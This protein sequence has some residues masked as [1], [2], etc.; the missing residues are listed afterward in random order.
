[1]QNE[2]QALHERH[3]MAVGEKTALSVAS[4]MGRVFEL[5]PAQVAEKWSPSKV[6]AHRSGRLRRRYENAFKS[7]SEKSLVPK[8]ANIAMFVKFEKEWSDVI[9]EKTPRAIQ[10]RT[11]RYTATISQYL[12]PIEKWLFGCDK[13]WAPNSPV[14][15]RI[16]AKG[17]NS[18]DR[19]SRLYSMWR[20]SD[21]T[22]VLLDHSRF[23]AN[24]NLHHIKWEKKIYCRLTAGDT[25]E[26]EELMNYQFRNTCYSGSGIKY[27][28]SGKKMSGEYNTSLGDSIINAS[29][30]QKWL[31]GIDA[32]FIVDGDDSVVA[33][34]T[35]D[36]HKLDMCYFKNN[37]WDTKIE[38]TR[39]FNHVEFCQARPVEIR[40][41]VWRMVRNPMRSL[42]RAVCTVQRYYG[43][44]WKRYLTSIGLCE[45][46]CGFG[47]PIL[48]EFARYLL[49]HGEGA[50]PL[51]TIQDDF[52]AKFEPH[53]RVQRMA[54][55]E[56]VRAS[57]ALTWGIDVPTQ[58]ALERYYSQ[59][60]HQNYVQRVIDRP[61]GELMCEFSTTYH[62]NVGQ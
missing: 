58:Y 44:A 40:P 5:L 55:S 31:D 18:F 53:L 10:Y 19:A 29:L 35:S 46:Y 27:K 61:M 8:D 1:M 56:S 45:W 2:M 25:R 21:T 28:C 3:I 60:K 12:M 26:L 23:D 9:Y 48:D 51:A 43:A 42:S 47:L 13:N 38:T 32:E 36:Y 41:G 49:R 11:P 22:W 7:L 33:I 57:F 34:R 54:I 17:L 20:W 4:Y 50:K 15:S 37:G 39:T 59:A 52:R 6:L 24:V 14:T 16:F 30:I 62:V